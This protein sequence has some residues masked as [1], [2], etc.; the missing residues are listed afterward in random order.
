MMA[1]FKANLLLQVHAY[2][3]C[4]TP[5]TVVTVRAQQAPD[6]DLKVHG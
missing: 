5:T 4:D 1:S 6:F 3:C 2:H